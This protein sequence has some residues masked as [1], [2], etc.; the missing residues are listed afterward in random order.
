MSRSPHRLV[1][2]VNAIFGSLV[3]S[4]RAEIRVM[5][6][7]AK[8]WWPIAVWI[9][10]FLAVCADAQSP[11]ITILSNGPPAHRLNIVLLSEGYT[12][13]QLGQFFLDATNT[14]N[15]FFS[16]P[17]F[18]EYRSYFNAFAIP[19]VSNQSGSDHPNG[20][21]YRDTYFNSSYDADSDLLITIPPNDFD[22]NY[23]HG[24]GRVDALL[25]TNLPECQL[26]IMLVNDPVRGGSDGSGRTAIA[27]TA[28]GSGV[29]VIHE[30]GH[31]LANLGDEYV[32]ENP[33]YPDTEEPNTTTETNL[34][35]IKW[36]AWI[37]TNSTPVPTPPTAQYA[38]S[39]GL[40]E[41]AHYHP[42]G[43]YRPQLNCAMG[44]FSAPFCAV[45]REALVLAIYQRIHAVDEFFP[46]QTNLSLSATQAI[47]FSISVL[48]PA[49][50][51]LSVQ[52]FTNAV[53]VP[54]EANLT[55]DPGLNWFTNAINQV[56]VRVADETPWV[57]NDPAD[58]LVQRVTWNMQVDAPQLWLD[59]A[60]F[61]PDGRFGFRVTGV[62]PDGF[63][64]ETSSNLW[65]W[66]VVETAALVNA[67]FFYTNAP[68]GDLVDQYFRARLLP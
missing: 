66:S 43:W 5:A 25:Q 24:Q 50:H 51:A 63:V 23:D 6:S 9:F 40:F 46:A 11:M 68:G 7:L 12:S 4:N 57:R 22:T 31:V 59:S 53:P 10:F 45:C 41:G 2:P 27:S 28:V 47:S 15:A 42:Q 17:P 62:A 20:A 33:G 37:D 65:N 29:F 44:N 32:F 48:Q 3:I 60:N 16:E 55:F 19:I 58:L 54:G 61:L 21:T 35:L 52:W 13:N 49:T 14:V 1:S 38:N 67:E 18:Q 36:R 26:P 64:I 34:D 39:V 30:S 56:S 8:P